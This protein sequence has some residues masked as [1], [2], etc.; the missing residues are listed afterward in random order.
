V[1]NLEV[2]EEIASKFGLAEELR[3]DNR[4][5]ALWLYRETNGKHSLILYMHLFKAVGFM[6]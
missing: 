1:I 2:L 6:Q 5:K 4:E 3:R